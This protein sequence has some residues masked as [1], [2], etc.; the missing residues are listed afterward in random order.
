MFKRPSTMTMTKTAKTLMQKIALAG[1]AAA[2]LIS[3]AAVAQQTDQLMPQPGEVR[4]TL[5][6][7]ARSV[8]FPAKMAP[9]A[10][11]QV[12]FEAGGHAVTPE[13]REAMIRLQEALFRQ[14]GGSLVLVVYGEDEALAYKRAKAVR[15]ELAERH[16]M[17]PARIIAS[18]RQANGHAG[19]LAVV[20]VYGADPTRCGGCGS[21][22]FRTIAL[23]SATMALVTLTPEAL[24][25]AAAATG[26]PAADKTAADKPASALAAQSAPRQTPR[27]VASTV[28]PAAKP[29]TTAPVAPV[30]E[31]RLSAAAGGCQRP[32]IIIDDYYPGG[33]IVPCRVAR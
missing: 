14:P 1:V 2:A 10:R 31:A 12:P 5:K 23:D 15:G 30:V 4:L 29:A 21:S 20:D 27:S 32:K 7:G 3:A 24:P 22:S 17:D 33:P 11:E 16:S 25:Q 26:K 9:I 6:M 19:D 18:G 28:S 8:A 13:G